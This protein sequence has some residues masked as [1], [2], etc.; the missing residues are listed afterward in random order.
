MAQSKP[1]LDV[2]VDDSDDDATFWVSF[3][4]Q[5]VLLQQRRIQ[6]RNIFRQVQELNAERRRAERRCKRLMVI[7]ARLCSR[8]RRLWSYPRG[9]AWWETTQRHLSD[10]DFKG[11]FRMSRSTFSYVVSVCECMRRVDT[12]KRKA[13]PLDKRVAIGIYRLAS[14]AEDRTVANVF[15]VS[16]ASVNIIF[17]EFC[18]VVVR[19]LETR[20]VRFPTRHGLAE[21]MRQFA[22]LTGF[23]QGVG[24]LDGCHIEVCPPKEQ[25]C[26]YHNFKGW[27]SV[28]LL[29]VV[30]QC[31]KFMYINVGTPG[32]NH[33]SDIFQKSKLPKILS[34]DLFNLDKKMIHGVP[35]GPVLLADQAFPLQKEVM[36]PF[37]VPGA[38]GS[39]SQV[40]NYH[41]SSARRV[42]ENAF[43]RLKAR[44]RILHKGLENDICN[45]RRIIRACCVLHNIC[46]ELN[47]RCDTSWLECVHFIDASR[48]QQQCTT[49]R[50]EPGGAEVRTALAALLAGN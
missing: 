45:A 12:N 47:D 18:E 50:S 31:Y 39:P 32:R 26:D 37:P 7:A 16:R 15:G 34:S 41:L 29:A 10:D 3:V 23:P 48:P 17:R 13:I 40:F 27:Y 49:N 28:I 42:V 43:G 36:K 24:A 19:V 20:F 6:E 14:S 4:A 25:A 30:D 1:T 8:D 9:P 2:S 44:F 5:Q 21:H 22:A 33:D 11:N 38:A 35:V 46:E